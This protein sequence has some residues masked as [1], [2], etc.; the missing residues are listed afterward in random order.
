MPYHEFREADRRTIHHQSGSR[1]HMRRSHAVLEARNFVAAYVK[2]NDPASRRLIQYLSMQ[3]YRVLLLVRDA[4]TGE[5]LISPP[6]DQLWLLREK[7]GLGRAAKNEWNV[8]KEVGPQFFNE[9]EV[10][11]K[12]NLGFN[13][14]YDV[15]VWDLDAGERCGNVYS[16]ITQVSLPGHYDFFMRSS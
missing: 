12:W 3:T 7:S 2:R 11:R 6:K 10:S 5:I 1:G 9:M 16:T 4:K 8:L 13:D 15:I 14:Y